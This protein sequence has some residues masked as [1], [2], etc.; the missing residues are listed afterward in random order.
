MTFN[1]SF[2]TRKSTGSDYRSI[3]LGDVWAMAGAPRAT[4]K[5][6]AQAII[7][8]SY[9]AADARSHDAQRTRGAYA[10]LTLDVDKGNLEGATVLGAMRAWAGDGV[11]M[12][13]YSSS[14]AQADV[15]K[16]RGMI[17]LAQPLRHADWHDLQSSFFDAIAAH[18]GV[19]PDHAL[20]RAG[21]PV[22]LPN[23]PP[24]KRGSD[25]EPL[26]YEH[27]AL[28]GAGLEWADDLVAAVRQARERDHAAAE[29]ARARRQSL[30]VAAEA[31]GGRDAKSRIEAFNAAHLID[32]LML[33]NGYTQRGQSRDWRSPYQTSE[34]YATRNY[35]THWVS[36]SDSDQRA[37]LG[38][39]MGSG[40][41]CCGDAFDIYAHFEHG[42]DKKRALR[43]L[44]DADRATSAP[45][46][47]IIDTIHALT[48]IT[49][50]DAGFGEHLDDDFD[51]PAAAPAAPQ[52]DDDLAALAK[53][54]VIFGDDLPEEYE[55]PN[56][57]V[58]GLMTQGS[59]TVVYGDSNSGKTFFALSV[60]GAIS[61][62]SECYG[63]KTEKGLVVYLASE[64][65]GS[66]KTRIQALKKH[67][68][69]NFEN[70]AIVPV[71]LNFYDGDGH[72]NDV[73]AMVK[74]VE[75]I[76]GM[77]VRLLVGDTLARMSAGAN[78]N[79]GE[80]MGPVMARFDRVASA[81]GAALMIIHHNGKDSAKGA[82][83]WSGI[84]AHIDTEIEV[85]EANGVRTATVTKQRELASKGEA[86][87][88]RLEVVEMGVTKF[89]DVATTCVALPDDTASVA[90]PAAKKPKLLTEAQRT[91][92]ATYCAAADAGHAV[93]LETGEFFGVHDDHWRAEFYRSRPPSSSPEASRKA[94]DRARDALHADGLLVKNQNGFFRITAPQV[95]IC[96][97]DFVAKNPKN[98]TTPPKTGDNRKQKP[99]WL[100]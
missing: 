69:C 89:G 4:A 21:Q 55:A 98:T 22:Y 97:A 54:G 19:Q 80:D 47:R 90:T 85:V 3:T 88:F 2:D 5:A 20:A 96:E 63:R 61:N 13:V 38:Q 70:L 28:G 60:A 27:V 37:G 82:R 77:P 41:G 73:V 50:A 43:A 44:W 87:G 31:G 32:D 86:I 18:T 14:S 81:T 35:G 9:R 26:F 51:P 58:Q 1:G 92:I 76:K 40:A 75:R 8:S 12:L 78:E 45:D 79:S 72:A 52:A 49:P 10:C 91:G 7:P 24:D 99:P 95:T 17:P 53:L 42:G 71:P 25:G 29:A 62:G 74:A 33:S 67:H 30:T 11:A 15:R 6:Q 36:L 57:L 66:I 65:P 84:R 46:K 64:A 93:A 39:A 23:V 59:L 83:G 100:V 48:S 16:W 68:G 94:Y 34:S 56:E